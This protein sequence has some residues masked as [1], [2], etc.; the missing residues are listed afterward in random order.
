MRLGPAEHRLLPRD[1]IV[2]LGPL[3]GVLRIAA[4]YGE[5]HVGPAVGADDH[6]LICGAERDAP[7]RARRLEAVELR[8][9]GNGINDDRIARSDSELARALEDR[10]RVDVAARLPSRVEGRRR[11][12]VAVEVLDVVEVARREAADGEVAR[13]ECDGADLLR[14][15]ALVELRIAVRVPDDAVEVHAAASHA[16]PVRRERN[17]R[18][19]RRATE[20]E[21]TRRGACRRAARGLARVEEAREVEEPDVVQRVVEQVVERLDLAIKEPDAEQVAYAAH[22]IIP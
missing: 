3:C 6:V 13:A 16:R 8:A 15:A 11:V 20:L 7:G 5:V 4:R 9:R 12:A 10:K 18:H 1:R 21:A 2:T 17:R 14:E 22:F 19:R